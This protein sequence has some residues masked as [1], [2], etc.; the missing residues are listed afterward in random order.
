MKAALRSRGNIY[1]SNDYQKP[2]CGP[3]QLL[4]RVKAA[5]INP[6]DYKLRWPLGGSVV[7]FDYAGVVEQIGV[8]VTADIAVGDEV[9]GWADSGS[10]AEYAVV[11]PDKTAHKPKSLSFVEAAS[12][13]I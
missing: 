3:S 4:V 13:G 9:Y 5:G 11:A 12:L 8:Q 10:L 7:G 1:F 6:V 2:T